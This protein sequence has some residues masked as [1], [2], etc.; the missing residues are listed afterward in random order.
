MSLAE[1]IQK[2]WHDQAKWLIVL[3]PLSWLYRAVFLWQKNSKSKDAYRAPVPVMIIGNITVGGSGK[4][5]LI[6]ALVEYLQ[7]K[8]IKVGV[9]SRGYGGK[10]EFPLLVTLDSTPEQVGDEPTLIVRRTHVPMAVGPKS[11]TC[12]RIVITTSSH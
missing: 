11:S 10:G 7:S 3:R 8:N 4:T 5:P 12:N 9:I 2:A 1:R 6:I